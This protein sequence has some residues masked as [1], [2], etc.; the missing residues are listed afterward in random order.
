VTADYAET[1]LETSLGIA[2][3]NLVAHPPLPHSNL[4][5]DIG[6]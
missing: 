3:I 6:I 1:A 5:G 4:F 2:I